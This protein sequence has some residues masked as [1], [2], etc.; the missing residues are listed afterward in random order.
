MKLWDWLD[1]ITLHKSSSSK[2]TNEDWDNWNS[3][4]VHRFISMGQKNI[5]I[6]N[7]AQRMHPTDK[8]GIYDFYC[9]MI[10][11][12]K[13]WNKYIKSNIKSKNKELLNTIAT[14]FECGYHEANH[15]IDIIGKKEVK[16][17][18][19][20]M[21]TEKKLITQLLKK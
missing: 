14:Y 9:N 11:K 17:I 6:A 2:F 21:G 13:V 18:L 3:Y 8:K 12:K 7:I 10:P 15:Y 19:L 20:S 4:M 5:E 1:E 16:N